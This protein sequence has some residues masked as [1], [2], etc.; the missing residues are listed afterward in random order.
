MGQAKT[1]APDFWIKLIG[2]RTGNQRLTQHQ[3]LNRVRFSI[4]RLDLPLEIQH[5]RYPIAPFSAPLG[6]EQP[7]SVGSRVRQ[8]GHKP[9]QGY[10]PRSPAG[11]YRWSGRAQVSS[12]SWLPPGA[13]PW[14]VERA[15]KL[16]GL[17]EGTPSSQAVA[18]NYNTPSC[19]SGLH[20]A[21]IADISSS[22]FS[23]VAP[24]PFL[25]N[26]PLPPLPHSSRRL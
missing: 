19:S 21:P 17:A 14:A 8:A 24:S 1:Q 15:I 9:G 3:I 2:T 7:G 10:Q 20:T 4:A 5:E 22:V 12:L 16:V 23:Q 25:P 18:Q 13:Q 26:R 6:S 11:R